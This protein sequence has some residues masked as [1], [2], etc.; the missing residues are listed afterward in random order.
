[1]D[2]AKPDAARLKAPKAVI[3]LPSSSLIFDT[4][5]AT[6]I[7]LAPS[8]DDSDLDRPERQLDLDLDFIP[9]PDLDLDLEPQMDFDLE[10]HPIH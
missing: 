2:K 4:G 7:T 3:L 9:D 8:P 6:Y 10:S 1:L 5:S